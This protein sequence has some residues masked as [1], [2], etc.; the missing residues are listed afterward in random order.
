MSEFCTY[1]CS[2]LMLAEICIWKFISFCR[3]TTKS[4]FLH[5]SFMFSFFFVRKM[6]LLTN[7]T[8]KYVKQLKVLVTGASTLSDMIT[9]QKLLDDV[10][11]I[12]ND[13]SKRWYTT[14]VRIRYHSIQPK[15]IYACEYSF[16]FDLL[17]YVKRIRSI[18]LI[19]CTV[20]GAC[21]NWTTS[22]V[23]GIWIV[24][25]SL[26]VGMDS[27]EYEGEYFKGNHRLHNVNPLPYSV[28]ARAPL[29]H[30]QANYTIS[31]LKYS[32][33]YY[34]LLASGCEKFHGA[35]L[36][37]KIMLVLYNNLVNPWTSDGR[38]NCG[39]ILQRYSWGVKFE[40]FNLGTTADLNWTDAQ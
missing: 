40:K 27:I 26:Q 32:L 29:P 37:V 17:N 20:F 39:T 5:N 11:I 16:N 30:L 25:C 14:K 23:V 31:P 2:N 24:S 35:S 34:N 6:V 4:F 12:L 18:Y 9:I 19:I 36:H 7:S 8:C 3:C 22:Q 21:F 15:S 10:L 28:I 38:H 33:S 13:I 1:L